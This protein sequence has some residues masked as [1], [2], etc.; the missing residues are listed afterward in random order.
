MPRLKNTTGSS[1]MQ[2]LSE[3]QPINFSDEFMDSK[4]PTV[5]QALSESST[6]LSSGI[7][8]ITQLSAEGPVNEDAAYGI[9]FILAG[10]K[11][12]LDCTLVNVVRAS[13]QVGAQ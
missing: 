9:L 4:L 8:L 7:A 6:L 13:A 5:S 2:H 11:A 1:R 10:A 3:T 12:L